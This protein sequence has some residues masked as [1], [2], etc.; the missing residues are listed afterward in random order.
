MNVLSTML[1]TSVAIAAIASVPA[2]A[3][4]VPESRLSVLVEACEAE[5]MKG[6]FRTQTTNGFAVRAHRERMKLLCIES[7]SVR[8]EASAEWLS[9]CRTE[10]RVAVRPFSRGNLDR[11]HMLRHLRLCGELAAAVNPDSN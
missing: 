4:S 9:R 1:L 11:L 2:R 3:S 10:S 8:S 5:A 6:H 7:M